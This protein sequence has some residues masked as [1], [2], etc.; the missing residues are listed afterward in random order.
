MGSS[1][2]CKRLVHC[3]AMFEREQKIGGP[4]SI[5][6]CPENLILIIFQ[7][8]QPRIHVGGVAVRIVRNAAFSHQE[9]AGEFGTELFLCI[10]NVAK[11]VAAIECLRSRVRVPRELRPGSN[12]VT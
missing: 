3:P 11:S 2:V 1:D 5:S 4:V 6:G 8:G 7:T 12:E 9:D 10:F